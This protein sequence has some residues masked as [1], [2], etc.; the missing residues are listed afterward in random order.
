MGIYG[1]IYIYMN[2]ILGIYGDSFTHRWLPPVSSSN[3]PRTILPK[4][5]FAAT[6]ATLTHIW[7]PLMLHAANKNLK[8]SYWPCFLFIRLGDAHPYK[9]QLDWCEL[10]KTEV[11]GFDQSQN[12]PCKFKSTG[13]CLNRQKRVLAS[14]T[15]ANRQ[16]Q[17]IDLLHKFCF[18][19]DMTYHHMNAVIRPVH[20]NNMNIWT[21]HF[22]CS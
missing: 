16:V 11:Q 14:M 5:W 22:F 8:H 1:D 2:L 20:V 4:L 10:Y 21:I 17:M 13:D 15:G 3:K 19:S 6:V 12:D 9:N 7:V 18:G